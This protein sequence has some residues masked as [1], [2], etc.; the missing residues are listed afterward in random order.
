MGVASYP[1]GWRCYRTRKVPGW[2]A[3]VA[4]AERK[5]QHSH[6]PHTQSKLRKK[7]KKK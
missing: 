6:I 3:R 4:A 5:Q 7:K 2:V 1:R